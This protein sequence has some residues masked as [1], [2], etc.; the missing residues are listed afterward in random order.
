MHVCLYI[1]MYVCMYIRKAVEIY[2]TTQKETHI[3]H[4]HQSMLYILY[5]ADK[6]KV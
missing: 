3:R 2:N 1:C 6:K 5:L 4:M